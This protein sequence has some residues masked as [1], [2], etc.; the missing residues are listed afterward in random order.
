MIVRSETPSDWAQA[1]AK[2]HGVRLRC[3]TPLPGDLPALKYEDGD[4]P[5]V[6]LDSRLPHERQNFSLA[7]EVAHVLLG[8]GGE[9][10][11]LE[12]N[13]ADTLASELLLPRELFEPEVWRPLRELKELFGHASFEAIARR[14]I[15]LT[16]GGL[17][18]WDNQKLVRRLS[19]LEFALPPQPVPPE[20][21]LARR[22][23]E[24]R[25]DQSEEGDGFTLEATFVDEG[26][27]VERVLLLVMQE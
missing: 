24:H 18:I 13:E 3:E 8:H 10:G 6:L 23:Y 20:Y 9:L 1:F 11:P 21:V 12:E 7:H 16:P 27:G 14:K 15:T 22:C 26:R 25:C 19:G 2:K 17:T 4:G 5:I